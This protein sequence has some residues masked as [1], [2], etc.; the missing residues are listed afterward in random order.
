M[1]DKWVSEQDGKPLINSAK[2]KGTHHPDLIAPNNVLVSVKG[3]PSFVCLCQDLN[4]PS[5]R[6]KAAGEGLPRVFIYVTISFSTRVNCSKWAKVI[7]S[8]VLSIT[9]VALESDRRWGGI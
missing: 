5:Q 8:V 7:T 1:V 9:S 3:G 6:S 2:G 4:L